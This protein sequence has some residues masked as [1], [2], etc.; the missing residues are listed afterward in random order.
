MQKT[1]V[2]V[3]VWFPGLMVDKSDL[4]GGLVSCQNYT[5]SC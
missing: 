5:I 1:A 3:K 4:R 2:L